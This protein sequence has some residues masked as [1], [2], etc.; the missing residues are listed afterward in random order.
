LAR[1]SFQAAQKILQDNE[2]QFPAKS[3]EAVQTQALLAKI[4][5]GMSS[6]S[7]VDKSGLDRSKLS[8][9]VENGS[10]VAGTAGKAAKVLQD[11]GYN[12]VSTGNA[13]NFN[14]EGVTIQVKDP[15]SNFVNLLKKDLS[16]DYTITSGTSDLAPDSP[17]DCIIII[18][19]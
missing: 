9:S 17:T 6:V 11:L 12:V 8:I 14:Y 16:G 13:D 1:D 5:N 2:G 19:K 18:G 15:L 7:P 3:K 4:G 10:G